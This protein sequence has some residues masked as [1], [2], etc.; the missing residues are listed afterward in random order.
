VAS[1]VPFQRGGEKRLR[2]D[3]ARGKLQSPRASIHIPS[4]VTHSAGVTIRNGSGGEFFQFLFRSQPG[5]LQDTTDFPACFLDFRAIRPGASGEAE[6]G[7]VVPV[8][9]NKQF[10]E[11]GGRG[12]SRTLSQTPE[13]TIFYDDVQ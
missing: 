2:R 12:P 4:C 3:A 10:T 9:G 7:N 1:A 11:V 13:I 8:Q 6:K 5:V